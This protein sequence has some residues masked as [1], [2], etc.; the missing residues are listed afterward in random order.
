[1]FGGGG[2]Q[3]SPDA[4]LIKARELAYVVLQSAVAESSPDG[5]ADPLTC[6]RLWALVHGIA[7]L[8]LEAGIKP[9]DYGFTSSEALAACLLAHEH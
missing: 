4:A 3:V 1:M 9:S 2:M 6:M 5:T 8:I 7:K